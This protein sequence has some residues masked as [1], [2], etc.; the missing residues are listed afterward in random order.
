M[1]IAIFDE[2]E[3][4]CKTGK[5]F[6]TTILTFLYD[7][8]KNLPFLDRQKSACLV[9]KLTREV[10]ISSIAK[11]VFNHHSLLP[12]QCFQKLSLS[13][14]PKLGIVWYSNVYERY[15]FPP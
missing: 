9:L 12:L 4:H 11:N 7:V 10:L 13:G 6:L 8:F 5:M 1:I 14:S 15:R 3:K 2:E